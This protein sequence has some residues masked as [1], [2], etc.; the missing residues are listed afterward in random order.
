MFHLLHY[1][2]S[3]AAGDANV[4]MTA[5]VDDE[6]SRRNSH[7]IF[8]EDYAAICAADL[9]VSATRSRLNVPRITAIARHQIWPVNRSATPPSN[10]RVA[11]WRDYPVDLPQDEEIA[12]EES[13]DLAMGNEDRTVFLWIAPRVAWN[14]NLP[15]GEQRLMVRVTASVARTADS[16]SALGALTFAENLRGGWYSV[17]HAYCQSA[18][19]RAFRLVFPRMPLIG[20]RKMRPGS[21]ATNAVGNLE[22]PFMP[23]FFGEWGRFHTFEPPQL[24]VYGD[25]AG[26]DT[27]ELRLDLIYMGAGGRP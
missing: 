24:Q 19:L 12:I 8:T 4:D 25:A 7:Y 3:S 22:E 11:D 5:G 27:Q 6:F 17:V 20:G 13:N 18:N 26:A 23:G 10:P 14:R 2:L 9:G 21:L 15:R 16:W 1:F